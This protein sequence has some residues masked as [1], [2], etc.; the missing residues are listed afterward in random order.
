MRW[1]CLAEIGKK[2]GSERQ[3]NPATPTNAWHDWASFSPHFATDCES[4]SGEPNVR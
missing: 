3:R 4:G 2:T 1:A